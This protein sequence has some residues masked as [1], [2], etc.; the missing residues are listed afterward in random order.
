MAVQAKSAA[1]KCSAETLVECAAC[2]GAGMVTP[3]ERVR[4]LLA[5]PE[6]EMGGR[7]SIVVESGNSD[8]DEDKPA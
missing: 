7:K 6:L 1:E 3:N 2:R 4:L 5:I 8:S